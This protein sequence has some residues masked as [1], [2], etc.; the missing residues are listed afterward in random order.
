MSALNTLVMYHI[1]AAICALVYFVCNDSCIDYIKVINK[2]GTGGFLSGTMWWIPQTT[3]RVSMMASILSTMQTLDA[4]G[5]FKSCYIGSHIL[6]FGFWCQQVFLICA[7][8]LWYFGI[9]SVGT[10]S[11]PIHINDQENHVGNDAY[12]IGYDLQD[13]Y[14][15]QVSGNPG[16]AY[17]GRL[18]DFPGMFFVCL[19]CLQLGNTHMGRTVKKKHCCNGCPKYIPILTSIV[20]TPAVMVACVTLIF[21]AHVL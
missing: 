8:V 6:W 17:Q 3:K 14:A 7:C 2:A 19:C 15:A 5:A 11:R 12:K 18:S 1:V 13:W 4:I 16:P 20:A 21:N 9:H 10:N